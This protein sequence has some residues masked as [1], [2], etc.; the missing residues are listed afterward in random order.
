MYSLEKINEIAMGNEDVVKRLNSIFVEQTIDKDLSTLKQ[1]AGSND[2]EGARGVAH[3]MK[4]ILELYQIKRSF[5][6]IR[7]IV[8]LNC[9]PSDP[10]IILILIEELEQELEIVKEQ[11]TS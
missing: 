11:L 3:K 8:H 6:I 2:W 5:E 4:P 1:F 10:Q 7:Q 9:D